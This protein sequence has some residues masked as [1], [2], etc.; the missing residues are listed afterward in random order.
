MSVCV[1]VFLYLL[2]T[3][4]QNPHST[5]K[6]RTVSRGEDNLAGFKVELELGLG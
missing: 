3:E 6:V 5:S 4:Y 2:H 1:C